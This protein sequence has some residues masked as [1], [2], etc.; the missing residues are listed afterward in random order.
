VNGGLKEAT[1]VAL[2][3]LIYSGGKVAV[4]GLGMLTADQQL[5]NLIEWLS[6]MQGALPEAAVVLVQEKT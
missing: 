3:L 5:N 6:K 4:R 2:C 1:G